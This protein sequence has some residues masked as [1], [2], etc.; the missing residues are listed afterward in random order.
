MGH[1]AGMTDRSLSRLP[2][3]TIELPGGVALRRRSLVPD[4]AFIDAV[5]ADTVH[6]GEWLRWAQHPPT[7]EETERFRSEQDADWD[8]GR[9]FV[10]LLTPLSS[11]D[12]VL[13]GCAMFPGNGAGVLEIGYWTCS[14]FTGRGLATQGAAAL[15]AEGLGLPGVEA[16]EIHCD[17]ANVRSARIPPRIGYRLVRVEPDEP[18]TA[19]EAGQSMVWRRDGLGAA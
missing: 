12:K 16:M 18:Q 13:G 14:A 3:E 4:D 8:A 7:R 11:S 15:T 6:L 9:S 19:A 10:Y 2:R 5:A 17:Q 1:D